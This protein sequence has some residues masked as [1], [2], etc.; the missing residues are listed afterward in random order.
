MCLVLGFCLSGTDQGAHYVLLLHTLML[1]SL[2]I[3]VWWHKEQ[4]ST[5]QRVDTF[6]NLCSLAHFMSFNHYHPKSI[7]ISL[8]NYT[9]PP[10]PLP[11]PNTHTSPYTQTRTENIQIAYFVGSL[12]RSHKPHYCIF[13]RGITCKYCGGAEVFLSKGQS[14]GLSIGSK[15][16][17]TNPWFW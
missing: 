11:P 12:S 8:W 10:H 14:R 13:N 1:R 4:Q 3:N 17:H 9:E 16:L 15:S 6:L 7:I 2:C 5:E